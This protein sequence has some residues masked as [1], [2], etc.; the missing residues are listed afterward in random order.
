MENGYASLYSGE[1]SL[2]SDSLCKRAVQSSFFSFRKNGCRNDLYLY[3][4]RTGGG[5]YLSFGFSG[6]PSYKRGRKTGLDWFPDQRRDSSRDK[7]GEAE[8]RLWFTCHGSFSQGERRLPYG[9]QFFQGIDPPLRESPLKSDRTGESKRH[10][11]R[12]SYELCSFHDCGERKRDSFLSEDR[13]LEGKW[14]FSMVG[15][16]RG[17]IL[18][19]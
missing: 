13:V 9:N 16:G 2:W 6:V 4:L 14:R 11:R 5:I 19:V 12:T 7:G 10:C 18:W 1:I 3:G 15:V 8:E 17:F